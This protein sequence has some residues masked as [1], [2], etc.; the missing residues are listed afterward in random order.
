MEHS[1]RK[2][3]R[4]RHRL[5][6]LL[7]T[8]SV[9]APIA[10]GTVGQA[11]ARAHE[12]RPVHLYVRSAP[13]RHGIPMESELGFSTYLGGSDFDS[14]PLTARD[15]F[16]NLYLAGDTCSSD[17]PTTPGAYQP[18]P[19]GGCDVFVTKLS[20][21]GGKLIY[22]TYLGGSDFEQAGG[23][24]VD[25]SGNAYVSGA[26]L[27]TDFPTTTGAFQNSSHG[28]FDAFVTKLNHA[29]SA[30]VYS[31]YLGGSG[32]DLG[33]TG[34]PISVDSAARVTVGGFTGSLDFP[35]TKGAFQ[36][37][38]AGGDGAHCGFPCDAFVARLNKAGSGLVYSTFLGGT[39]DEVC[40]A[41]VEVDRLGRAHITGFTDS[42]DYPTRPGAF[43]TT[44]G[45]GGDDIYVTTL[46]ARGSALV[47]STYLG[48]TGTDFPNGL[49]IDR[50]GN[51]YVSGASDSPD[52]PTTAGAYQP[53]NAGEFDGT[54]TKL[55]PSGT[56]LVYSTYLGGTGTEFAEGVAVDH[57]GNAY[58]SGVTTSTDLPITD[59]AIQPTFA[60]GGDGTLCFGLPCDALAMKLSPDASTLLYSTYLGG[61][62]DDWAA[63]GLEV[64]GSRN[65]YV[66]GFTSSV[67]FPTTE[68]AFQ[69]TLAGYVDAFV[70]KIELDEEAPGHQV[71]RRG[72][73]TPVR[74]RVWP[75]DPTL[76]LRGLPRTR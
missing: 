75:V 42:T 65:V 34:G 61:S 14:Y 30:L 15:R 73:P 63:G 62:G 25:A 33:G 3:L 59:D 9:I 28:G 50:K 12:G 74:D 60:G 67:D 29:G 70:T 5:L 36:E 17:F 7:V 71:V 27:S 10:V 11:N 52:F 31:T 6:T 1:R 16:G 8:C 19:P 38:F 56:A 41:G 55:S 39:A 48:S 13:G 76:G 2:G 18:S 68:G 40:C 44:Y 51:T 37:T 32:D 23:F 66:P 45:G 54:L 21:D 43:Q 46:N 53:S 20:P 24:T 26:T 47:F 49:T 22:S 35:V 57:A 4:G 58:V 72:P 69:T 64:D